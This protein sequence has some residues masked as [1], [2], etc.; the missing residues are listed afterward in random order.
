MTTKLSSFINRIEPSPTLRISDLARKLKAEGK[1]IVSLSAGEPDFVTPHHICDAAI[2]AINAGDTHYT[3]VGGTAEL[4][5]AIIEKLK[6]ENNL[7]YKPNQIVAATGCKQALF[8]LFL[9]LLDAGDEAIVPAPYWVSYIDIIKAANATPVVIESSIENKFKI[10]AEQLE[11][12][13]TDKT[14]LFVINSPSNPSGQVYSKEE[15][16]AIGAVLKKHPQIYIATDDIYE[17]LI[18][19]GKF[20]NIINACP[21]LY[22]RTIVLNGVSKSYAMT[23]WRL[24]FAAGPAD[25]I[26]AMDKLQSQSTSNPC[27]IAQAAAIEAFRGPQQCIADMLKTYK[28]R[29]DFVISELRKIKDVECIDSDGTFYIFFS[30]QEIL[31][32]N[33]QFKSD[34][35][36]CEFLMERGL[37]LVPG[38]SFGMPGFMRLSFASSDE[39]L[40]KGLN[41]LKLSIEELQ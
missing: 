4:K 35:D 34:M 23:G 19:D 24:G 18:F 3:A 14:K 11:Q 15:L 31:K 9:V 37:A 20:H 25:I 8:N 38:S 5:S 28:K 10:T 32:N 13:I 17:H 40:Q 7:E 12:A 16:A 33:P 27:S 2:A 22:S 21:E 36:F 6:R 41:K 30:V 39:N 1:D 29:H 26:K